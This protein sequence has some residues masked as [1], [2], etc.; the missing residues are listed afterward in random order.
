MPTPA[1]LRVSSDQVSLARVSVLVLICS[2]S[3]AAAAAD[4]ARPT[5]VPPPSV[6]APARARIAV[7]LPAPAGAIASCSRAPEVAIVR[8]SAA[9]PA[10]RVTPLAA[11]SS[12][13]MSTAESATACPSTRPCHGHQALLGL[14]D[15]GRGEQ[16][17]AGDG[18][19]AGPVR[20]AQLVGF[21]DARLGP[22]Q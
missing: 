15:P 13:A 3:A 8:T 17:G 7:V 22:G 16:L 19:D 5:T 12:R 4:G 21:D 14:Q 10:L 6:Q 11:D 9:C 1:G 18:V 20:A 2:R